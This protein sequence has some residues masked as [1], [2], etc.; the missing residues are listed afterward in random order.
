[1]SFNHNE[2]KSLIRKIFQKCKPI[3]L[4]FD[5]PKMI[6]VLISFIPP[7]IREDFLFLKFRQKGGG[8]KKIDQKQGVS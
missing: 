7:K 4:F 1:M 3:R 6:I 5:V 8:N 2:I